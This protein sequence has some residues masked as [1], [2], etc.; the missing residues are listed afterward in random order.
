[1]G[2]Y[3]RRVP[4]TVFKI[5]QHG[6]DDGGIAGRGRIVVEINGGHGVSLKWLL[7]EEIEPLR[8]PSPALPLSGEEVTP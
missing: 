8:N 5:R 1:M 4:E 3:A 6:F 2:V 7:P